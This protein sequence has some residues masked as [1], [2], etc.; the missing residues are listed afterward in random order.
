MLT[1]PDGPQSLRARAAE[2]VRSA[3]VAGEL[4]P[5]QVCS[6]PTLAAQLGV[7]GT[8]VREALLDLAKEG[9]LEPLRNKGFRVT[10]LTDEDLDAI[11]R[12]REMLEVPV[13]ADVVAVATPEDLARLQEVADR[14]GDAARRGSLPDYLAADRDFHLGLIALTG[15]HRLV[16]IVSSLRS[17][18]R[19][20]G[21]AP[22][23]ARNALGTS[24]HEHQ[25]L[26]QLVADGDAPGAQ[27]LM[28]AHLGHVRGSWAGRAER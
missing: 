26:L 22:L 7:S 6:V 23:A 17:Q 10:M 25:S 16:E 13:L 27:E 4:Q 2:L 5:G 12:I 11:T 8:P 15:N 14:I 3:I 28:R 9:L 19:L 18:T 24:A 21:L 1:L 20:L